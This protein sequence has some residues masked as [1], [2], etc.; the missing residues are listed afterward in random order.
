MGSILEREIAQQPEVIR[1][2]LDTQTENAQAIAH[3][4]TWKIFLYIDCGE[5]QLR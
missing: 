1:N 5:R 4:L 2:F 3:N